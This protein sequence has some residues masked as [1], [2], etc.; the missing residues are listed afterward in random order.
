MGRVMIS[1]CSPEAINK[2]VKVKINNEFF[3]TRLMEETFG[4]LY[5]SYDSWQRKVSREES[6]QDSESSFDSEDVPESIN[7]G[8]FREEELQRLEAE[9]SNSKKRC[10]EISGDKDC[11][12]SSRHSD[13]SDERRDWYVKRINE[14]HLLIGV[15]AE[16]GVIRFC[17]GKVRVLVVVQFSVLRGGVN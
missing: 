10:Q 1:T 4:E 3:S 2:L 17:W 15:S 11:C 16:K 14:V 13:T 6:S 9:Y 7:Y 5:L 8:E 12:C